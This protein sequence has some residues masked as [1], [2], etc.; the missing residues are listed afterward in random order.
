[1][2]GPGFDYPEKREPPPSPMDY[3]GFANPEHLGPYYNDFE[4]SRPP[5]M[6]ESRI[7]EY[8]PPP[9]DEQEYDRPTN[10]GKKS[11]IKHKRPSYSNTEAHHKN[12]GN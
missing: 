12:T 11:S 3:P 6:D 2:D 10:Y 8:D 1:M 4:Q 5:S 7:D 9:K